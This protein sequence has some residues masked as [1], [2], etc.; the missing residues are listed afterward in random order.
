M[1]WKGDF[2][3]FGTEGGSHGQQKLFSLVGAF[4]EGVS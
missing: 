4:S 1:G 3:W 2:L